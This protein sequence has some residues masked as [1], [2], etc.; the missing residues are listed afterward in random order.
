MKMVM[1]DGPSPFLCEGSSTRE[2]QRAR[3]YEESFE[4]ERGLLGFGLYNMPKSSRRGKGKIPKLIT[5]NVLAED[6]LEKKGRTCNVR[7]AT[8][9]RVCMVWC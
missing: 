8:S 2:E 3:F 5:A 6:I 9:A 1:A 4:E 7:A